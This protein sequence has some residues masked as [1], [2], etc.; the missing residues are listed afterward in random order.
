MRLKI[1][2]FHKAVQEYD[3]QSYSFIQESLGS[4]SILRT[5]TR[6]E[7]SVK[8]A[9]DKLDK[10]VCA[11]LNRARFIATCSSIVYALIRLS[12]FLGVAV[13]GIRLFEGVITYGMMAA[14]LQLIR[15]ADLPLAEVTSAV[16]QFFNMIAS[17]ERLI[18]IEKL[19][20]DYNDEFVSSEAAREYYDHKLS[21]IGFEKVS[22]SYD[23]DNREMVLNRFDLEIEK[24]SY[25]DSSA[26]IRRK[27]YYDPSGNLTGYQ[28][29]EFDQLGR[30]SGWRN[31]E[32]AYGNGIELYEYCVV[33]FGDNGLPARND[34]YNPDGSER[35]YQT[36]EYDDRGLEVRRDAYSNGSHMGYYLTYYD[37]EG[38]ETG[39]DTYNADGSMAMYSRYDYDENGSL[40]QQNNYNPDGTLIRVI[41]PSDE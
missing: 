7:Y 36:M 27:N 28:I 20:P 21:S 3:G 29:N 4:M 30:R 37:D 32:N 34:Y 1:K 40:L 13:C 16:P 41:K 18:E 33:T 19:E 14:V 23:E 8:E 31:Y 24:G 9:G 39:Y 22:F 26:Q 25:V 11:R 12:Y 2:N 10:V 5:F 15:Q 6:E 38:K 35:A 17:A